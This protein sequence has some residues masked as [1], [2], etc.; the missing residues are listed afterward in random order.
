MLSAGDKHNY[1][2]KRVHYTL[3][4]IST[5]HVR[6]TYVRISNLLRLL[7]VCVG[8]MVLQGGG[9]F[10][11]VFFLLCTVVLYTSDCC[12]YACIYMFS[13]GN[14]VAVCW[15]VHVQ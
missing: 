3:H 13:W 8:G 5:V 1:V 10:T 12:S 9:V 4:L 15:C 6:T 2:D 11:C 7:H 14:G